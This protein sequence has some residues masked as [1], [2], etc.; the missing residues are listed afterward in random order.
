MSNIEVSKQGAYLLKNIQAIEENLANG[1][2][3]YTV[4]VNER[5]ERVG[6]CP[7]G[8]VWSCAEC[9]LRCSF[10]SNEEGK[11]NL[12]C[13]PYSVTDSRV[14][15]FTNEKGD[16][17]LGIFIED[18]LAYEFQYPYVSAEEMNYAD[19]EINIFM[20]HGSIKGK[21]H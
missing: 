17:R 4:D 16:K 12:S 3:Y 18:F 6:E 2:H 13:F 21:N 5:R 20:I 19:K 1:L 11:V 7:R 8:A 9:Y 10:I 15:S 14:A